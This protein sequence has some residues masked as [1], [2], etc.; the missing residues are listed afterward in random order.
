MSQMQSGLNKF[1]VYASSLSLWIKH[2]AVLNTWAR[3]FDLIDILKSEISFIN[4]V[5]V[6]SGRHVSNSISF[7]EAGAQC[8]L[9]WRKKR[10]KWLMVIEDILEEGVGHTV[11]V[12]KWRKMLPSGWYEPVAWEAMN[13]MSFKWCIWS[14]GQR[15]RRVKSQ[16]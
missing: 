16:L 10:H 11:R 5:N 8:L 12:S 3:S 9:K 14:L 7:N 15:W 1:I 13:C 6:S 4:G 2:A